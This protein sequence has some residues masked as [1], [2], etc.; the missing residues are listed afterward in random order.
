MAHN[1]A[2]SLARIKDMKAV[3][4]TTEWVAADRT[5]ALGFATT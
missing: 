2:I 3:T 4:E 5:R 1:I